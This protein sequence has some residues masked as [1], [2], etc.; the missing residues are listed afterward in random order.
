MLFYPNIHNYQRNSFRN[1]PANPLFSPHH[2]FNPQNRQISYNWTSIYLFLFLFYE[3]HTHTHTEAGTVQKT[4]TVIV[5]VYTSFLYKNYKKFIAT[6]WTWKYITGISIEILIYTHICTCNCRS[7]TQ[8]M[9]KSNENCRVKIR[10]YICKIHITYR[11]IN[12]SNLCMYKWK[13][14]CV[15]IPRR[16]RGSHRRA[17]GELR[18]ASQLGGSWGLCRCLRLTEWGAIRTDNNA[19]SVLA[20]SFWKGFCDSLI[21][22]L[23]IYIVWL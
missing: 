2:Q 14:M 4:R 1:L 7:E 15:Y 16:R 13:Q 12:I 9:Y 17:V 3:I 23:F 8:K 21:T 5:F 19:R 18:T 11:Y 10:L 20:G 22:R 6:T